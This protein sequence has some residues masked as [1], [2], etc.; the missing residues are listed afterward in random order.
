M[1]KTIIDLW[2][3]LESFNKYIICIDDNN[4]LYIREQK[5]EVVK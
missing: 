4:I 2:I 3:D 1:D 5:P